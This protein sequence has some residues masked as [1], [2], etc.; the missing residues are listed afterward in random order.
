M[1]QDQR[2]E[3][4]RLEEQVDS[5]LG[6]RFCFLLLILN[7]LLWVLVM[8]ADTSAIR[9][10]AYGTLLIAGNVLFGIGVIIG[11]RRTYVVTRAVPK[12]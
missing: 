7:S 12:D 9:Q 3:I 1:G 2:I 11:R 5:T 10:A 6:G 4:A 8:G